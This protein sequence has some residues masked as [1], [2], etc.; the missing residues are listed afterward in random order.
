MVDDRFIRRA[1]AWLQL[2]EQTS[3]TA[4]EY[5]A[6]HAVASLAL[7]LEAVDADATARGLADGEARERTKAEAIIAACIEGMRAW[8]RDEDNEVHPG[9][10]DAYNRAMLYLGWAHSQPADMSAM[11][12]AIDHAAPAQPPPTLVVPEPTAKQRTCSACAGMGCGECR[13]LDADVADLLRRRAEM[14]QAQPPPTREEPVCPHCG[15]RRRC[16]MVGEPPPAAPPAEQ[17]A[18]PDCGT[19]WLI[20]ECPIRNGRRREQ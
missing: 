15:E 7:M 20:H 2:D 13:D 1:R 9:A 11:R 6:A 10:W 18:C 17:G 12:Q 16:G 8:S 19:Q 5:T 4:D 3:Q 14:A